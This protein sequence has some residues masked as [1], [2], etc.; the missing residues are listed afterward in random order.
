M[1]RMTARV[2]LGLSGEEFF[3][4]WNAGLFAEPDSHQGAMDVAILLPFVR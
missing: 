2:M 1:T 4:A 3:K